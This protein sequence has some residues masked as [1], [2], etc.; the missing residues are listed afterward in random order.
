MVDGL[1]TP[2]MPRLMKMSRS[3]TP[4]LCVIGYDRIASEV[5]ISFGAVQSIPIDT[6]G[7]SKVLKRWVPRM[8]TDDQKRTWLDISRYLLS[9]YEDDPEPVVTEDETWVHQNQNQKCR[10]SH[11]STL[12]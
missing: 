8:L 2:K 6:L 4:W 1:A 5:G 11:G 7:L 3:C 10:T 9:C 12:A